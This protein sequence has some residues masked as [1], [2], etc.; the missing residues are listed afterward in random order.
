MVAGGSCCR[1]NASGSRHVRRAL[2]RIGDGQQ[3]WLA[4]DGLTP[5]HAI[6]ASIRSKTGS[7]AEQR[8]RYVSRKGT[9]IRLRVEAVNRWYVHDWNTLDNKIRSSIVEGVS[10]FLSM[11]DLPSVAR[12]FCPPAPEAR[13]RRRPA[14]LEP[15]DTHGTDTTPLAAI[16]LSGDLPPLDQLIESGPTRA[17]RSGAAANV[18][19]APSA[20]ATAAHGANRRHRDQQDRHQRLR[21]GVD[22]DRI[23][24]DERRGGSQHQQARDAQGEE[25]G[26]RRGQHR[27]PP[28]PAHRRGERR[29]HV[30]RDERREDAFLRDDEPAVRGPDDR[31]RHPAAVVPAAAR[32]APP[33]T[34]IQPAMTS[35]AG[36]S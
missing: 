13:Q 2:H 6:S 1:L 14:D 36:L 8:V 34:A 28:P 22:G 24:P 19:T 35:T 23:R 30:E 15:T 31:P 17:P 25:D 9:Q 32:M 20:T 11:F 33:V 4:R 29:R 3:R 27:R 21:E 18:A 7:G 16:A 12:V 5:P 26:G 10:V